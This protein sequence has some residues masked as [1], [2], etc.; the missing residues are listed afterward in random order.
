MYLRRGWEQFYRAYDLRH[1]YFLLFRYDGDAM[2]TV[3]V[4]NTTMCH[5]RYQDDDDA[6]N[7]SSSTDSG[8]NKS[9]DE[10]IRNGVGKKR[11]RVGMRRCW[12][13]MGKTWW[14]LRMT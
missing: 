5:M 4:F 7:G 6:S 9:S 8:Y 3:K 1:G 14:W 12:L 10:D 11:S 2:L 13:M